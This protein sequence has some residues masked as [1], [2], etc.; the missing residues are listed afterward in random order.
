MESSSSDVVPVVVIGGGL[1]GLTAAAHLAERG[2]L[3]LVLEADGLWAGGRLSGGALE[4]FTYQGR[5]WSFPTE[6]GMHALWGGY[7]NMRA[8]L[9]RFTTTELAPSDG[10]EWINRWGRAVRRIEAGTAVRSG[11]LPAPF[12]YLQLLFR[13]R[14]WSTITPLDFL[15]LPGFLATLL[16]TVGFDPLREEAALDGM[17]LDDYFRG[18]TPN[19]RATFIGLAKNLLAAPRETISWTAM[20]AAV[21]FFTMLRRD[22]WHPHYLTDHADAAVI[23]PLIAAIRARGGEVMLGA[24][25]QA[26]RRTSEGWRVSVEDQM[27]GGVRAVLAKHVVL[28]VDPPAAERLLLASEST[29]P[30]AE[31]LRFPGAVRTTTARLWFARQPNAGTSGG[32]LTGDFAFDNFFWLHRM[33]PAFRRWAD[34]T[35]GSVIELHLYGTDSQLDEP[36]Q[37]IAI[38]AVDEVQRAFPEVRGSFVHHAV[39]HNSRT[40]TV[41][42][43]PTADSLRVTTPWQDVTACGDWIGFETPSLWMERSCTTAVAAANVILRA[44][45]CEPFALV[46]PP[47]PE[48]L[49]RALG[50]L[51]RGGRRLFAPAVRGLRRRRQKGGQEI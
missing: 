10:E 48:A 21:R 5:V 4:T 19:L 12:H 2:V 22:S 39:R 1:A 27:R 49:V 16:M 17:T 50:G 34:E 11:W 7:G 46:E 45:G 44:E 31:G 51:V 9:E 32:M 47:P 33:Q 14:F 38:R 23:Q 24:T 30:A 35:G 41:F 36:D 15:S 8:T 37:V 42:R 28:A 18:W 20:I 40:Q 6:H 3:P 29:R 43:V 25:A 13:P 26:L